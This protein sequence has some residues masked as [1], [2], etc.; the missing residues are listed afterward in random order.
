MD[1]GFEAVG[2]FFVS[3]GDSAELFDAAEEALDEIATFVVV[4]IVRS[5]MRAIGFRRNHRSG[6]SVLDESDQRIGIVGFIG[7][8]PL[9]GH[10]LQQG[11]GLWE[12]RGLSRSDAEARQLAQT[13]NQRVDFGAQSAS[14]TTQCLIAFFGG[15]PA[16]C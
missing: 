3:C 16:A 2:E 10:I 13:L 11:L 5:L 14:G 9:S 8:D 15:A 1:E 6:A 7:C 4:A 12:V